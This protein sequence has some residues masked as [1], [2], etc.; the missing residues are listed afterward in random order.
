MADKGLVSFLK[1]P[2][3]KRWFVA[4]YASCM[5]AKYKR[6]YEPFLGGGSVF[7]HLRPAK[8]TITDINPELINMYT[9]MRDDPYGL[10][11]ILVYHQEHH[12]PEHYYE[13]RRD[14]PDASIER[15]GRFLYLNRT[16]FNG[17]YR[18]NQRGM[19]NVPI[20]TKHDCIYDIDLFD[21]YSKILKK[22]TIRVDDF[23]KT[24]GRAREGDI[25]F[26]DPPYT[27]AHNQNSFIKYNEHLF[28]WADQERLFRALR[29]AKDRGAI[30]FLTNA[31]HQAVRDMY[32]DNGFHI[33]VLKRYSSI[34]GVKEKRGIQEE[35]LITS[36][37]IEEV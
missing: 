16:C 23:A 30:V 18:V 25:I 26:A 7:F 35:L 12:S 33:T 13:V 19:F 6:Y 27:I 1:W 3:G 31:N 21:E 32:N 28:T 20:G 17:M 29:A 37:P 24:I 8:A 22:A 4:K 36:I 2:G 10:R 34:S 11:E 5:P 9:A 15:A 14:N